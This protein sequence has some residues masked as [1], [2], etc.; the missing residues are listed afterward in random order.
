MRCKTFQGFLNNEEN[1]LSDI[2]DNEDNNNIKSE[3]ELLKKL[4]DCLKLNASNFD[5]K[6]CNT[7]IH[8]YGH[9]YEAIRNGFKFTLMVVISKGKCKNQKIHHLFYQKGKTKTETIEYSELKA[10]RFESEG[11]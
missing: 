11:F 3:V 9:L 8:E 7:I 5:K 10:L 2:L 1:K 4:L 6:A